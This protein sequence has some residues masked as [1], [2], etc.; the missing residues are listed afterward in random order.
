[1]AS[2][3]S[4][5]ILH[6]LPIILGPLLATLL[7]LAP[8]DLALPAKLT[9]G[10]V[11]WVAS[12]WLSPLIPLHLSGL[13]GLMLAHFFGLAPWAELLKSFADPIIF[14]FMGGFFLAQAVEFHQLDKWMSASKLK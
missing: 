1:M 8:L 11:L 12:W 10:I 7:W 9:A 3:S 6:Y 14:L 4:H 2:T 5:R 13:V